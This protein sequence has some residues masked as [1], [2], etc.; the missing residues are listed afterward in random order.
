MTLP[1]APDALHGDAQRLLRTWSAPDAEQERRRL[2]FLD[3][4]DA[5]PTAMWRDGSPSHLTA[6]CVV[7]D[8]DATH[9]LLTLHRKAGLWLQFGGH[10]EVGD[11]SVHAAA[12]RE[13]RE[14]S[15]ITD[16][17]L[18]PDVVD[19]DRHALGGGFTRCAE[20][21]DVRFV[22]VANPDAQ[23]AVSE[24][25]DDVRWWPVVDLPTLTSPDLVRL[26]RAAVAVVSAPSRRPLRSARVVQEERQQEDRG[27]QPGQRGGGCPTAVCEPL[28]GSGDRRESDQRNGDQYPDD[29]PDR[30]PGT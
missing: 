25:S 8:A 9:V 29:Q 28:G 23:P 24:E 6:S 12:A 30:A 16:L 15:G 20:H 18:R 4:L 13:A 26:V 22:A 7:L 2:G 17:D 27:D 21:L 5:E 14:E 11:S 10:H 3:H 1:T 19:L